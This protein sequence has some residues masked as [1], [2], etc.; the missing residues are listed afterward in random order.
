[1]TFADE[2]VAHLR[3]NGVEHC[4]IGAVALQAWGFT[5]FTA[6]VDVMTL[7]PRVLVRSFWD[8]PEL[9]ARLD[10]IRTGDSSDPLVGV[11][12]FKP[13][14]ALD[15]VVMRDALARETIQTAVHDAPLGWRVATPLALAL[16]KLEAGGRQDLT[17]VYRLVLAR[18]VAAPDQDLVAAI[19]ARVAELSDWGKRSWERLRDDLE[20]IGDRSPSGWASFERASDAIEVDDADPETD[21]DPSNTRD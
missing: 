1:L 3:D 2:V 13:V 10:K 21:R 18:K 16:M 19:R 20:G 7:D 5:R 14:P 4:V 15:I 8:K 17:D 9:V 11:V 6:D 12:R